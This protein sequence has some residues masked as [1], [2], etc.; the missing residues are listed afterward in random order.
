MPDLEM[1]QLANALLRSA[2][3]QFRRDGIQIGQSFPQSML[4]EPIEPLGRDVEG[5][6]DAA[7]ATGYDS[8]TGTTILPFT[9][10][11]SILYASGTG[12]ILTG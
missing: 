12:D 3:A 4:N 9:T 7:F 2:S 8:G 1:N 6:F 10:D 11:V 5:V